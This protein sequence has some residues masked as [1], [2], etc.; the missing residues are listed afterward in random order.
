MQ[1]FAK[2]F[3]GA[4]SSNFASY[5]PGCA[6][7]DD[8][9]SVLKSLITLRLN[10]LSPRICF[11]HLGFGKE[12]LDLTSSLGECVLDIGPD[13]GYQMRESS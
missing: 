7:T 12:K 11:L 2:S 1:P 3:F 13:A 9:W 8:V 4:D 10:L 6:P 5:R